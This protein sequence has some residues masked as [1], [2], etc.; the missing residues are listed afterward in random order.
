MSVAVLVKVIDNPRLF[1]FALRRFPFALAYRHVTL[2]Y[3]L[4]ACRIMSHENLL[5]VKQNKLCTLLL[6]WPFAVGLANPVV[7]TDSLMMKRRRGR[8]CP[9]HQWTQRG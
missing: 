6:R 9:H 4:A 7:E 3:R 1:S 8:E 2:P 5:V